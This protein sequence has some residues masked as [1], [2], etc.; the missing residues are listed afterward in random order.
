M[1]ATLRPASEPRSDSALST[2]AS[3]QSALLTAR[4]P[5]RH[6]PKKRHFR[7]HNKSCPLAPES[8]SKGD[9]DAVR[10]RMVH[11]PATATSPNNH[12]GATDSTKGAAL[13]PAL[14]RLICG[15]F[16]DRGVCSSQ[17]PFDSAD[18][19]IPWWHQETLRFPPLRDW[20]QDPSLEGNHL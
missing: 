13:Q 15:P 4:G 20:C 17:G 9:R 12:A 10:P 2:S 19:G 5:R 16:N 3:V 11:F 7:H 1:E 6:S 18:T 14:R 8:S